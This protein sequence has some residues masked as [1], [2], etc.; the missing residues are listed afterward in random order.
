VVSYN[1]YR[2]GCGF[3]R[4]DTTGARIFLGATVLAKCGIKR[5]AKGD[6]ISFHIVRDRFG[7]TD[8]AVN[9]RVIYV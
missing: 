5:L 9:V 3:A 4:A 7:G 2:G 1:P 6:R 8:R